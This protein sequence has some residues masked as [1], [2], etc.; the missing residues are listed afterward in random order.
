M[1]T[2]NYSKDFTNNNTYTADSPAKTN[3]VKIKRNRAD[4][5]QDEVEEAW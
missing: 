2:I 5:G 3:I 4:N 1:E